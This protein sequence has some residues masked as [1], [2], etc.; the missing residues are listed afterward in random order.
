MLETE[1]TLPNPNAPTQGE[2]NVS[3]IRVLTGL[4]GVRMRPAMYIGSSG[5]QGLHHLVYEVVDNSIDEA[6]GGHA[7]NVD[8]TIHLD[9]SV[10]VTDDG[11]GIPTDPHPAAPGKSTVEVVLTML[12]A[13]GKFEKE[14]Y[15]FS[16]GLHGVGVSVVNALSEWLE[17][18]VK[19]GGKIHR[20]RFER[21][22]AVTP[23]EV[24][25]PT[26]KTGTSV[27]FLADHKIF[28]TV[29]CNYDT[30][31][32]RLRELA[33]LNKGVSVTIRDERGEGRSHKFCYA[34]GIV[35]F[36]G[37][38]NQGKTVINPTP[39]YFHMD[40]QVSKP[41]MDE[42]GRASCRERVYI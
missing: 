4:E 38:L 20:Q 29:E 32:N 33:F 3:S 16:G 25:G 27:R 42:I 23:L 6:L 11:R 19:R 39:V 2:Y 28:E 18:E 10:T 26:K 15:K 8:V 34:G 41:T 14:A 21:G 31:A 24:V 7:R 35:E 36:V 1:E 5:P 9:N 37:S 13:G 22:D 17:V 12:H 30:L 40:K